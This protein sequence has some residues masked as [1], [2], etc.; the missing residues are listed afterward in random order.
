MLIDGEMPTK[1]SARAREHL[2]IC[3]TCRVDLEKVESTISQ[4][5]DFRNR[6]HLPLSPAP[7]RKW[8]KFDAGLAAIKEEIS[9]PKRP[10]IRLSGL[11]PFQMRL[12]IA[13]VSFLVIFAL[14]LQLVMVEP[15]S[16]SELLKKAKDSQNARMAMSVDPVLYQKL[17]ISVDEAEAVSLEVWYYAERSRIRR[18]VDKTK[19]I[20]DAITELSTVLTRNLMNPEQP[21]S[22]DSFKA[23]HESLADKADEIT[24]SDSIELRTINRGPGLDGEISESTLKFRRSDFHPYEQIIK[25]TKASISRT[26]TIT[27]LDFGILSLKTLKP[28]FFDSTSNRPEIASIKD[29]NS[30]TSALETPEVSAQNLP[31]AGPVEIVPA[32]TADLEVE[33]LRLLSSAQADLGDEVTVKRE[34]GLLFVRGLVET[35]SRRT[36]ILNALAS[37]RTNPAVRI[38]L[39]TV[40]EAL[41]K[42]RNN[43]SARP[44]GVETLETDSLGSAAERELV[45]RFGS[46]AEA[47]NFASKVVSRASQAMSHVYALRRLAKQFSAAEIKALSPD[48]RSKWLALIRTHAAG[49]K[50]ASQ[51]IS[52]DL[53]NALGSSAAT[54][55]TNV[56]I[57]SDADISVAVESLFSVAST[58]DR[59]IRSS[60]TISAGGAKVTALRS[61]QFWQSMK[62]A[63]AVAARIAAIR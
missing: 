16:A 40:D 38:E 34:R 20:P 42:Q 55:S 57:N 63:E 37:V 31:A 3:W 14:L 35:P 1:I 30:N 23:W 6:V 15:V 60:L 36:E 9:A 33:V 46:E 2:E 48:A 13:S 51:S 4:F 54:G 18:S 25:T 49:F 61:T 39:D 7:P 41:A 8:D 43:P 26:F 50:A 28:G 17:S 45:Q 53:A 24:E 52:V 29:T 32:A 10:W 22:P 11:S 19:K 47:R 59:L 56:V 27:E 12:G 21:L 62:N 44:S 5:I 58:N